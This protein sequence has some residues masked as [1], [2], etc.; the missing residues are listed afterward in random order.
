MERHKENYLNEDTVKERAK[1]LKEAYE[2]KK[3]DK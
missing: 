1:T 3:N 2:K